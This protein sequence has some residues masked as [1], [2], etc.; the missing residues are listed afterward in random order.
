MSLKKTCST[1]ARIESLGH[2]TYTTPQSIYSSK[3]HKHESTSTTELTF[4]FVDWKDSSPGRGQGLYNIGKD[5]TAHAT[6]TVELR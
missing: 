3:D 4:A 6:T 2:S 5:S 1:S